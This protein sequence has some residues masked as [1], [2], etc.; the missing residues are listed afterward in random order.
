MGNHIDA[1]KRV[2]KNTL[3]MSVRMIIILAISLY[4]A[5]IILES[6]G[7]SDYGVYNVVGG[8]VAMFA[9]FN[10]SL[11]GATQRFFNVELGQN[12]TNGIQ[13][14]FCCSFK[15]HLYLAILVLII[16]EPVGIWYIINK[17]VLPVGQ[18]IPAIWVFEFC[19]LSLAINIFKAPYTA[20]IMAYERM[21]AYAVIEI[22]YTILK[23]LVAISIFIIPTNKLIWFGAFNLIVTIIIAGTYIIYSRKIIVGIRLEF[24]PERGFYKEMLSFS[25]WGVFG[26]IAYMLRDQGLSLVL[27]SFF[28]TI[29]NAAKGVTDQINSAVNGFIANIVVPVRPQIIQSYTQNDYNRV[30]NLT[31]MVS[32]IVCLLFYM[33]SLPICFEI[34]PILHL[35]LG[36]NIPPHTAIF[37][38]IVLITNTFGTL[39]SPL[40]AIIHASGRIKL[41]QIISSTSNL[42]TL[43][44]AFIFLKVSP[45]P[46]MAYV[47][48]FITMVSN[49]LT[50]LYSAHR[51][52]NLPY[53]PY[54]KNVLLP[55]FKVIFISLPLIYIP[56]LIMPNGL[57]RLITIC[58]ICFVTVIIATYY[59]ALNSI[60]KGVIKRYLNVIKQKYHTK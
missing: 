16:I 25:G 55:I 37:T 5:R 26:S 6:L 40:S 8:F 17:M 32:K 1:N 53:I 52:G 22:G 3:F 20:A 60:E 23:L 54:L 11:A 58:I 39:V 35:W 33:L 30:E 56:V 45:I 31:F 29:V 41:Y 7:I 43:P 27:N 2:A 34:N 9:F 21:D 28:G 46:E 15:I 42:M 14:V 12:N 59:M 38:I 44:L 13:K 49:F 18:L 36:D 57:I 47:A 50:T 48:L 4:T 51:E 24:H 10:N 19:T